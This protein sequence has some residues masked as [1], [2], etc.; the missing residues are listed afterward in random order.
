MYVKQKFKAFEC[1]SYY[2]FIKKQK[3][4]PFTK[5]IEKKPPKNKNIP[6]LIYKKLESLKQQNTNDDELKTH[7]ETTKNELS[8]CFSNMFKDE[9]SSIK[10]N[11]HHYI[12]KTIKEKFSNN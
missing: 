3:P 8:K 4:G 5:I 1:N 11:N 2:I 9:T 12:E 10:T 6:S 7:L